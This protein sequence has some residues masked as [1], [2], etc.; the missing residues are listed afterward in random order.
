ML[1][2]LDSLQSLVDQLPRSRG[3]Y[4]LYFRLACSVEVRI[5][6]GRR[7]VLAPGL[8]AYVGSAGGPGGLR[9]RLSRHLLGRVSRL[10][11][12]IDHVTTSSC[13]NPVGVSICVGAYGRA[14]EACTSRRLEGEGF[15]PLHGFGATDDP[16]SHS[17]LYILEP[18]GVEKAHMCLA[19]CCTGVHS[20]LLLRSATV[21]GKL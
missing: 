13:Y 8:Y 21:P 5:G 12:H 16:S 19:S 11:W 6:G 17:H 3:F 1:L 18:A 9:A 15:T 4:I 2:H 14:C 7:L 20:L 10:H